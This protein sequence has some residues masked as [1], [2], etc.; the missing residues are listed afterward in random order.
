[1]ANFANKDY[2]KGS[3]KYAIALVQAIKEKTQLFTEKKVNNETVKV[4]L[5][6]IKQDNYFET[7]IGNIGV[8]VNPPSGL[9]SMEDGTH[10]A[11]NKIFKGT[12]SGYNGN[13]KSNNSNG[14][15]LADA[16]ELA[17]ILSLTKDINTPEDTEQKIFIDD[18]SSFAS[19]KNT[20]DNTRDRVK[21]VIKYPLNN[22]N[23]YHDATTTKRNSIADIFG[24][25]AKKIGV[26]KDSYNPA[27]VY[28]V[29]K[30][31]EKEVCSSL[32]KILLFDKNTFITSVNQEIYKFYQNGWLYPISLKK[33]VDK[34]KIEYSNIPNKKLPSYKI[35]SINCHMKWTTGEEIGVISF[36]KDD[37]KR[38]TMQTKGYPRDYSVSQTEMTS[39]GTSSGGRVGKIPTKVIDSTFAKFGMSRI[40]NKSY[41]GNSNNM[42]LT[43]VTD[44][45]IDTWY[46]LYEK[47]KK[48]VVGTHENITKQNFKNLFYA[49]KHDKELATDLVHK[50]QGLVFLHI[51]ITNYLHI[52]EIA[53]DFVYGAKKIS[54]NN[55]FF[56]KIY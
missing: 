32:L 49:G 47:T 27:D 16:G 24:R 35:K 23:I 48:F 4:P 54:T 9:F 7:F 22:Y 31:H 37:G 2:S 53:T 55:S 33:L 19:W 15:A 28:L 13:K 5:S 10:I 42:Y 12:F 14:R 40:K 36:V 6:P 46:A 51:Y 45:M 11:F 30:Q 20:F 18:L 50:V 41:F 3:Y 39:D 52:N 34:G 17:T 38:I 8:S 1:M 29:H 21:E 25:I 43:E 56:I 44:K 26:A